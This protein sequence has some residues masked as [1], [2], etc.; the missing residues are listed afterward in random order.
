M[1]ALALYANANAALVLTTR[2]GTQP[3]GASEAIALGIPLVL[4]DI[5]T[6]RRLYKDSPVYVDNVPES[7]SK[8][9]KFALGNY[10]GCVSKISGLRLSLQNEAEQQVDLLRRN[11]V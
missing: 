11:I 1:I 10:E 5:K 7:I 3:S 2:E 8:G 4:S 6:T 9:I